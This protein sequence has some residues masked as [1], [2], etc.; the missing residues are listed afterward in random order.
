MSYDITLEN[1]DI[2]KWLS[3]SE[4][5]PLYEKALNKAFETNSKADWKIADRLSDIRKYPGKTLKTVDGIKKLTPVHSF[6]N[7]FVNPF[8]HGRY[9]ESDALRYGI[10]VSPVNQLNPNIQYEVA[11]VIGEVVQGN[12]TEKA[13]QE[14]TKKYAPIADL[15]SKASKKITKD[16]G[17]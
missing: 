16:Q 14:R 7:G 10:N 4:L 13:A 6:E 9:G 1:G 2:V 8:T 17:L 5:H 15:E 3:K 12:I 11:S